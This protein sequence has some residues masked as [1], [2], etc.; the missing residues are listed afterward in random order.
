M[1]EEYEN[2]AEKAEELVKEALDQG[3]GE[4][5]RSDATQRPRWME[6]L[7]VSTALFAVLAAVASLLAGDTANEALYK[8]NLATLSQAKA[9]DTWSAFQADSVQKYLQATH[10]ETL[11]LLKAPPERIEAARRE[12]ARRQKVQDRL[13][14][15]ATQQDRE[16]RALLEESRR[17]LAQH[18]VF[19][20]GLTFFQ[21]A[22]GLSAIAALLRKRW[23]WWA[24]LLLGGLGL[25]Q[26]LRGLLKMFP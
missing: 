20:L 21:V 2:P 19:A 14:E 10:A 18:Q 3:H 26:L 15:E 5:P 24:S 22:I 13:R 9:A 16:T 8:S 7:A 17:L 23:V 6:Y 25:L 11:T 12:A 4:S 1:P